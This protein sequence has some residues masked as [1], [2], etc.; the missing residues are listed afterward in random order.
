MLVLARAEARVVEDARASEGIARLQSA[1]AAMWRDGD[2][3][4]GIPAP[5]LGL[6]V[7]LCPEEREALFG[8]ASSD[9][10]SAF[11]RLGLDPAAAPS[12]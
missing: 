12:R 11:A 1:L 6:V 7:P 9:L 8:D 4:A 10:H 3:M 2:G 5:R